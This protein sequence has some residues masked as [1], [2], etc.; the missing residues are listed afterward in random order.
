[1]CKL[2]NGEHLVDAVPCLSI[3]Y[4]SSF[5]CQQE[6]VTAGQYDERSFIITSNAAQKCRRSFKRHVGAEQGG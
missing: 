5:T 2:M 6:D 4:G 1:M 3:S